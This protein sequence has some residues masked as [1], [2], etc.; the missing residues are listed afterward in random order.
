MPTNWYLFLLTALI[1]LIVG[2]VYYN[3]NVMGNTWMKT[4]G[5]TEDLIKEKNPN[6]LVTFVATYLFSVLLSFFM[7]SVVIHQGAVFSLMYPDILEAGNSA[8]ATYNSIMETYGDRHRSFMHGGI[9]GAML[10]VFV[11]LPIVS[12]ISLF[13]MR[14]WKYIFIHFLYWLICLVLIGGVLCKFLNYA[15]L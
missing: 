7:S 6:M 9:H 1:P 14:G 15:P 11:V 13:E 4:N 2:F 5:F 8:Q 12:I 3:K 10:S